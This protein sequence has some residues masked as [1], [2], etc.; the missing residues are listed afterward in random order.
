MCRVQ[1]VR[2]SLKRIVARYF[3]VYCSLQVCVEPCLFITI[4]A[5]MQVQSFVGG[6][7][8]VFKP[9]WLIAC[10]NERALVPKEPKYLVYACESTRKDMEFVVDRFGDHFTRHTTPEELSLTF[11][12]V[13]PTT[14]SWN[15]CDLNCVLTTQGLSFMFICLHAN[16]CSY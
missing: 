12:K 11:A 2:V 6:T 16:A 7:K 1:T 8:D 3:C 13:R 10:L 14:G 9:E 5:A 15:S 4:P